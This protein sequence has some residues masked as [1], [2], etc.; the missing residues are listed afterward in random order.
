LI[1][2]KITIWLIPIIPIVYVKSLGKDVIFHVT[3]ANT[4]IFALWTEV[5][6]SFATIRFCVF[7]GIFSYSSARVFGNQFYALNDSMCFLMF[8]NHLDINRF[9]R[10]K[11]FSFKLAS[12]SIP[13]YSPSVFFRI[14]TTSTLLYSFVLEGKY[15]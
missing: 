4:M 2:E 10:M 14:V 12:C 3:S 6:S 9:K 7:E 1:Y 8:T 13:L 5:N 11:I 15:F